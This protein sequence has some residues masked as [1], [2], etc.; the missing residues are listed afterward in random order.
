M[1][2]IFELTFMGLFILPLISYG[3]REAEQEQEEPPVTPLTGDQII[4]DHTVIEKFDNIPQEYIDEVKKMLVA[5]IG[6]SH[7]EA[8]RTGMELLEQENPEYACNVSTA[9]GYTDQYVRVEDF[10]WVGEH[11]WFTWFAYDE[12]SRPYPYSEEITNTI[13]SY[14][15]AGHPFSALG[16]GWC[17]DMV[18]DGGN[19]STNIDPVYKVHWYGASKGGPE[20]DR[21][22]GLDEGD[23]A[24]TGNSVNLETYFGAMEEYIAHCASE[25]PT[26]RIIFTTGPVDYEG[27]YVGE[28]AYQGHIKHEAIKAYVREDSTRILF[29]YADILC[30][31]DDGNL[32]TKEWN[33]YTY[34]SISPTNELPRATGHISETGAIRLAKAQWWMLARIAGWDGETTD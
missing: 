23:Y 30:Y 21:C 26:T 11:I 3:C 15:N 8:Y 20:G 27:D 14:N 25:S 24:I 32:T 1:K 19:A 22:W 6:E 17:G 34:P 28:A 10:G 16:F 13:T 33:G 5:F 2:K 7:S 9:E 18:I 29:D 12:V 31:D 4:A